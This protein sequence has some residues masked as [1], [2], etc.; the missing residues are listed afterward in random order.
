MWFNGCP[1]EFLSSFRP[2]G[3]SRTQLKVCLASGPFPSLSLSLLISLRAWKQPFGDAKNTV[4]DNI[5]RYKLPVMVRRIFLSLTPMS[6]ELTWGSSSASSRLTPF[7]EPKQSEHFTLAMA[8]FYSKINDP[9]SK[10]AVFFAVCRGKV[11][12]GLDFTNKNGRAVVVTGLPFP[13]VK[14]AAHIQ[15][16]SPVIPT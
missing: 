3:F 13:N 2:M 6:Y 9:D 5:C 11:S 10:G 14:V 7:Q 16:S 1:T 8:D 12:E 4:W 15:Y